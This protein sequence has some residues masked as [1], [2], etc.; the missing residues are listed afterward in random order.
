MVFGLEG[1]ASVGVEA[2]DM[3]KF[4]TIET[5][6]TLVRLVRMGRRVFF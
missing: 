3:P 4:D 1:I 5:G 6:A 2:N